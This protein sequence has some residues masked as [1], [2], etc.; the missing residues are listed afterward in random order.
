MLYASGLIN[1][2]ELCVGNEP[3][4]LVPSLE[5]GVSVFSRVPT[6]FRFSWCQSSAARS[7]SQKA[8]RNPEV[9]GANVLYG[10][11][12]TIFVGLLFL[13]PT[14]KEGVCNFDFSALSPFFSDRLRVPVKVR[15][16]LWFF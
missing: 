5:P 11:M 12:P 2:D 13:R 7:R 15:V 8:Q 3:I 1:G 4:R 10:L 16:M 14:F 9:A 6:F